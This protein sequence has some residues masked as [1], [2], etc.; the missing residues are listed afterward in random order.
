VLFTIPEDEYSFSRS[1][2]APM[3][4]IQTLATAA[5]ARLQPE[6]ASPRIPSV[7]EIAAT[8]KAR[9]PRPEPVAADEMKISFQSLKK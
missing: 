5:A 6:R 1:L 9:P 2:A 7:T 8:Q 4:L 3:N